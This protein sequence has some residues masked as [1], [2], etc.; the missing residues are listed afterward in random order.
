M[1]STLPVSHRRPRER[2]GPTENR[3]SGLRASILDT[4][5]ELGV[6]SSNT[7]TNWIFNAVEE[8][9]E[10][11]DSIA[12]PSLT[13]SS[14]VTSEESSSSNSPY[15][16][17]GQPGAGRSPLGPGGKP[18]NPSQVEYSQQNGLTATGGIVTDTPPQQRTIQFDLRG[19]TPEPRVPS[20]L[21]P[22]PK[23]GGKLRKPRP[24][25]Y[26]SDGG[27]VSDGSKPKKEKKSKKKKS[28]DANQTDY[29]SDG[30]YLSESA[31]K[32]KEK[33]E[34]KEKEKEKKSK[35][36]KSKN[37][38]Y[39][40]YESDGGY[41]SSIGFGRKKKASKDAEATGDES[42][43]GALS[44]SSTKKRFFRLKSKSRKKQ[45]SADQSLQE[46]VPPVPALPP[47]QLPIADQFARIDS[48]S[49]TP[50]TFQ[51]ARTVTPAFSERTVTDR[52]SD[53]APSSR[54]SPHS[55]LAS[56]RSLVNPFKDAESV[57][58]PSVDMLST[59]RRPA[60]MTSEQQHTPP[61]N[62]SQ[63]TSPPGS[64][65]ISPS[66]VQTANMNNNNNAFDMQGTVPQITLPK[67]KKNLSMKRTP[68][69]ISAPNTSAL[70]AQ[71]HTPLPLTITPPTPTSSAT[72]L[73]PDRTLKSS[74]SESSFSSAGYATA[75]SDHTH[76]R[77]SAASTSSSS[78]GD[79]PFQS[80]WDHQNV[81]GRT[82]DVPRTPSPN[83][84][85]LNTDSLISIPPSP[86]RAPSPGP[87]PQRSHILAYY[88]LPPPSPPPTG[89]LPTVPGGID[90]AQRAVSP[91]A[92]AQNAALRNK[93][94]KD[95]MNIAD[96]PP[97]S[98]IWKTPAEMR[99]GGNA[100]A[101]IAPSSPFR[102]PA[103]SRSTPGTPLSS[104]SQPTPSPS[105]PLFL[106]RTLSN[107]QQRGRTSPF[108]VQPVLPPAESADLVRRTSIS[109]TRSGLGS[110]S[111]SVT[112]YGGEEREREGGRR[113]Q[114]RGM[115]PPPVKVNVAAGEDD[116]GYDYSYDGEGR[117]GDEEFER[118]RLAA[119]WQPRSASAMDVRDGNLSRFGSRSRSRS[120]EGGRRSW[121]DSEDTADEL[122]AAIKA[123][124]S[125]ATN[126]N[127]EMNA[128]LDMLRRRGSERGGRNRRNRNDVDV[129]EANRV[130]AVST[131]DDDPNT[132]D[133]LYYDYSD[134]DPEV[135]GRSI[136]ERYSVWSEK[137]RA[138]ILD[139]E[140]SE[141]VRARFVKRVEAMYGKEVPIPPVPSL[142]GRV[143]NPP[144]A[145]MF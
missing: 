62:R 58:H 94:S 43:G 100:S 69:Q 80:P 106:Q 121:A 93:A 15:F 30:G 3:T 76:T 140:R 77:D 120:R 92:R 37:G 117:E 45:D 56:P 11:N 102:P 133:T 123:R 110:R 66:A 72:L 18:M 25:G 130:S 73:S 48:R 142:P 127:P 84:S 19:A 144:R 2:P 31:A 4:A 101:P 81:Q 115:H 108:P 97:P 27:Y 7:V 24:D 34:K 21:P 89:P 87:G 8:V 29:E 33:K 135:E 107:Q 91:F 53:D 16:F 137:S 128:V 51:T 5:L 49:D 95:N 12:S 139:P 68:P 50:S 54:D 74:R 23:V 114:R 143:G 60:P 70:V 32:K 99:A 141:D 61:T 64:G 39:T 86:R 17:P 78:L 59:F 98:P 129:D 63:L 13:Y 96:R 82:A 104:R 125:N 109:Q 124:T 116:Y 35:K 83:P 136:S 22:P 145:N 65:S 41:M 38:D 67:P 103:H 132:R 138:S 111:N 112:R 26:E 113:Q 46:I 79:R 10:D 14:T 90:P 6:G 52:T 42:D 119:R 9:D 44:E 126:V 85:T 131:Y 75:A 88:D 36:D 47:L 122:E 1:H 57:R 28:A 55:P 118:Q 134:V 105:T 20:P 71:K 40:D